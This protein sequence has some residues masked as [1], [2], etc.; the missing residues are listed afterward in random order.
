MFKIGVP[1]PSAG[2]EA[3]AGP[4]TLIGGGGTKQPAWQF[5]ARELQ[6]IMQLVV[7]EVRGVE[8]PWLGETTFG[9]VVCARAGPHAAIAAIAR[10]IAKA[11]MAASPS[12]V[13]H[14]S[15]S[16]RADRWARPFALPCLT[17]LPLPAA[18]DRPGEW[19]KRSVRIISSGAMKPVKS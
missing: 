11:L 9:V 18:V 12:L 2:L 4:G 10:I 16:I 5:A 6:D 17:L 8:S 1:V 3:A 7:V 15:R 13:L 14:S 19:A